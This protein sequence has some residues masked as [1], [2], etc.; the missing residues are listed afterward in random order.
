MP[1]V[2]TP[3]LVLRKFEFGETSQVLH[4][5]TREMGRVHALAK[6]SL[7]EGS[8]FLGPLDV[9]ELGD[10]RI[11]PRR[12]AL[13]ILGSFER[14]SAFPGARR[15]LERL[16]GVF[17]ILEILAEASRE[18]QAD[19]ALFDLGVAALRGIEACPAE[20]VPVAVLRFDLGALGVLG[21]G[22]VLGA[23]VACGRGL[24]DEKA[25][26]LSPARGGALCGGCAGQDPLALAATRG[27]LA[28]LAGIAEGTRVALGPRDLRQA[29]RLV[30]GLLRHAF[31]KAVRGTG[32]R[33]RARRAAATSRPAPP[34]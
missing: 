16:E 28:A 15:V 27:V 1:S 11:Y 13:A 24:A 22:P 14:E 21:V 7:K 31:E 6:G 19:P 33:R 12:D 32:G 26:M 17:A 20:R 5:L 30:D 3:A 25:P 8:A 4:L 2:R 10:A 29:R 23:C 9:L 18:D 34:A